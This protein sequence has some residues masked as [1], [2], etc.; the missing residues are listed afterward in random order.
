MGS[1][2][3]VPAAK[4]LPIGSDQAKYC[5]LTLAPESP[6]PGPQQWYTG[7]VLFPRASPVQLLLVYLIGGVPVWASV[8]ASVGGTVRDPA[9][10]LVSGAE[11]TLLNANTGL[12]RKASTD[13]HGS[14][15]FTE[16]P[17]GHYRLIASAH[18]F[19]TYSSPELGLNANDALRVDIPL[20]I[21]PVSES[22]EVS[23]ASVHL[24]DLGTQNGGLTTAA[25]I[26]ALPL[27]GRSYT[28]LLALAPGV[29]PVSAGTLPGSITLGGSAHTGNVS[30]S[31]SRESANGFEVNGAQ[32]EETRLNAA[33]VVPNLDSIAEFRVVTSGADAEYGHYSGG[34]VNVITKSGSNE[35]HGG[36]FEFF[37]NESLDARNFFDAGKGLL[38]RNQ[39]GG[40]VGEPLRRNALFFF[41]AF[42]DTRETRGQST[43]QIFVPT[44]AERLG[45]FSASA[46]E[47]L[48]GSVGG[49]AF[50]ANLS[51]KLGYAVSP[52]E[53][54]YTSGCQSG[55]QCVFPHGIIPRQ[56]FSTTATA[57]LPYIPQPT[58][59]ALVFSSS[60]DYNIQNDK[61]G[62]FR[63]DGNTRTGVLSFYTSIDYSDLSKQFGSNNVPGFP[64]MDRV[65]SQQANVGYTVTFGPTLANEFRV[66]MLRYVVQTDV[67]KAGLGKGLLSRLGFNGLYPA[68]PTLEGVPAISFNNFTIGTPQFVYDAY[69]TAPQASDNFSVVRGGHALKF[70]AQ[71][72]YTN[73]VDRFPLLFGNGLFSFTGAETGSDF[74]DFLIGAPSS[75]TQQSSIDAD[76]RKPY[77][78][79]YGEDS[80]RA[81]KNLT[82]NFG[83][84]WEYLP[85]F[86]ERF[87][88]KATFAPGVQSAVFPTAPAG[89][90]YVG[91]RIP[92]FGKIPGTVSRTPLDN[93]APR[94]GLAYSPFVRDGLLAKL[95]GEPGSASIRASYG[96]YYTTIEGIGVYFSDPP[97]PFS[98]LYVSASPP[99]FSDPYTDRTTG[100]VNASPFLGVRAPSRDAI[101][102]SRYEPII[103]LPVTSV[104][105]RTPYSE[106][107]S[108]SLD[109]ELGRSTIMRVAYVGAEGHHLLATLPN[110]PASP[111][112]CI[113][114]GNPANLAPGSPTC[115]PFGEDGTYTLSN[116]QL[117]YGTRQAFP[118]PGF[119]DNTYVSTVANSAYHGLEASVSVHSA[120]TNLVAAYTFSKSLDDSSAFDDTPLNPFNYRLSRSLSAF[121]V[122]HNF[123]ISYVCNVP[124]PSFRAGKLSGIL[125]GWQVAGVTRFATG[126]PVT[127]SENDDRSLLGLLG[128]GVGIFV[129]IDE[130]NFRGGKLK[131]GDPRTG[132]PYFDTSAF[133]PEPIG[134]LG[135]ANR[136]FFHGPGIENFDI[137]A[138]KNWR[139]GE[140]ASV[141][142]RMEFFNAFNHVQFQNPA[143]NI[144]DIRS[145]GH[146]LS[147][148]DPRIGQLA[149]RLGF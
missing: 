62:S 42:Q 3:M 99:N 50:A 148:R 68:A 79:I 126:L 127:V 105:N 16:I 111:S 24:Q 120:S 146:V 141:Q 95:L 61:L 82:L 72:Q 5:I 4:A 133:S 77:A 56:A 54:Y 23:D 43:G 7:Y 104:H 108:V 118:G 28:D 1:V 34:V 35:M 107:F 20:H 63:L 52:G 29:V 12:E 97:V 22:V 84:R 73:F 76:E 138:L 39:F 125:A 81:T 57:L 46:D 109:R 30:V 8:T 38:H 131:F 26:E 53:P 142:F 64:T 6:N 13:G 137:A 140:R 69:E 116:G 94:I 135:N 87:N 83:L 123:V 18:G 37:R 66:S 103:G 88:Q 85:N 59:G 27:N 124:G 93:F 89:L 33:G 136:R 25:V 117:V 70:G 75:F 41:A 15:A 130:P 90:V 143:A 58:S 100:A 48:T 40:N 55:D 121:D 71:F 132:K 9:C 67:P 112:R 147:A 86:H 91:D 145:F 80:W 31:G 19:E 47:L 114:L 49:P 134:Q 78:G 149:L 102:F 144:T 101:D 51:Q 129:G 139:A 122:A 10:A 96:I 106:K 74:A 14:Y 65:R 2:V 115:G 21:G 44:A 98:P 36:A 92:G 110:N 32:A 113:F 45:D 17:V 60:A 11:I 119:G 128:S